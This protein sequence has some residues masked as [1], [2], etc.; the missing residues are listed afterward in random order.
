V[1][2]NAAA[3]PFGPALVSAVRLAQVDDASSRHAQARGDDILAVKAA[4]GAPDD[5]IEGSPVIVHILVRL[6]PGSRG[7]TP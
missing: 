6:H 7:G 4:A 3:E 2:P 1:A 5:T